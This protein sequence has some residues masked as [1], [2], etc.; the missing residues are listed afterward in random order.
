MNISN[1]Q[2]ILLLSGKSMLLINNENENEKLLKQMRVDGWQLIHIFKIFK[3]IYAI[4]GATLILFSTP[5]SFLL[6]L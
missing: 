4:C 1:E 6:L 2:N 5:I 3:A